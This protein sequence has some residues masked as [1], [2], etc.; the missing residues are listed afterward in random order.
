MQVRKD[1]NGELADL[2]LENWM[3]CMCITD[4]MQ[5]Y[6]KHEGEDGEF[7]APGGKCNECGEQ[8][9]KQI[10]MLSKLQFHLGKKRN[11]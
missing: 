5:Y 7:S 2:V 11:M 4:V 9:P 8:I 6:H 10:D 1:S 3:V